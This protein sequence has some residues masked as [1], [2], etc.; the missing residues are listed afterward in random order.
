MWTSA[1][2][3]LAWPREIFV[4]ELDAIVAHPYR[5]M[6]EEQLES[7]IEEAFSSDEPVEAYVAAR[8]AG[9]EL[10]RKFVDELLDRRHSLVESSAQRPYWLERKFGRGQPIDKEMLYRRFADLID[11]L[12]RNGYLDNEL[13]EQC[14][15]LNQRDP[16]VDAGRVLLERLGRRVFWPLEPDSWDDDTFYG[17]VE[18]FHDL[19][20]RPRSTSTCRVS[21]CIGHYS[22][23]SVEFGRALYRWRI[24]RLLEACGD[25]LRLG[26]AGEDVGRLVQATDDARA[27]LVARAL[28]TKEPASG[29][30]RTV[31]SRLFAVVALRTM[32]TRFGDDGAPFDPGGTQEASEG[33]VAQTGLG[34]AVPDRQW[35]D[36]RHRD[37]KQHTDYD[38]AFRDWVFWWYLAPSSSP[39]GYSTASGGRSPQRRNTDRM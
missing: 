23:F 1:D 15:A 7:L 32:T 26:D 36:L 12:R 20:A 33:R 39:T 14:P 3:E 4:R 28:A 35:F 17:L 10:Q 19:V 31:P 37:D 24:N 13:T 18:V 29:A 22:D 5:Q 21:G 8:S 6:S 38:P 34:R 25:P 16:S 30:G 27:D 9:D 11:D 2:Y